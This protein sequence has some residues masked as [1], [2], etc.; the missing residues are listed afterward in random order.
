MPAGPGWRGRLSCQTFLT[1]SGD[2]REASLALSP[3][4]VERSRGLAQM[5][6]PFSTTAAKQYA[7]AVGIA[8]LSLGL[9]WAVI[10]LV[11]LRIPYMFF[12]I[13]I[14]AA[15]FYCGLGPALLVLLIGAI[16]ASGLFGRWGGLTIDN[17]ADLVALG[18]Y[19]LA[20]LAAIAIGAGT[21]SAHL[22][23]QRNLYDV[24]QLHGLG[25]QLAATPGLPEQLHLILTRLAGLIGADKGLLSFYDRAENRLKIATSFGFSPEGLAQLEGVRGGDGACG[26]ACLEGRRVVVRDTE[27]D[28][29]FRNF[30]NL[31]RQEGFRAVHSTPIFGADEQVLGAVTYH[32]AQIHAPDT[33]EKHLTEICARN[34]AVHVER[35]RSEEKL[36]EGELRLRRVVDASAVPFTIMQP[37]RDA[38]DSIVDF[39]WV[40]V[41]RSAA[42]IL[43]HE[44]SNLLGRKVS[45]VLPGTWDAPGLFDYYVAALLNNEV[46]EFEFHSVQNG[47]EGWFHVVAYELEGNLAIWFAD[48]TQRKSQEIELRTA[49]RRKDEFLATLAHELRNPLA[50]IRQAA[51]LLRKP[52]ASAAQK[53]WCN[54]VIERQVRQMSLLLDDLLDV[55]RITRGQLQLKKQPTRLRS[56]VDSAIETSRPLIDGKKHELVVTVDQGDCEIDVDPMR[57]EQVIANLLNNAAKYTPNRGHIR[58][59]ASVHEDRLLLSVSDTG[60]GMRAADLQSIFEMFSQV[61]SA[62]EFSEGGLGIGLAL[63]RGLVELHDGQIRAETAGPGKGSTFR[64]EI[65]RVI[66]AA[67]TDS[68]APL[69]VAQLSVSRRILVADDNR[70]AA[71]SLAM[72]LRSD[73]HQVLIAHDGESAVA[74]FLAHAPEIA[75][76]D[77]GMPRLSGYEVAR[78]I[79]AAPH[80]GAATLIAITGWGQGSDRAKSADAG[81]DHHVT[82]PVDYEALRQLL[83]SRR[84]PQR[85]DSRLSAER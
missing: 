40:Y 65:P 30:R 60:I 27:T 57:M 29:C 15:A 34:I 42:R 7:I 28:A 11:G 46:R 18:I 23:S 51:L 14:G 17:P 54:E 70:D 83:G 63:T 2:C 22:R 77:I 69:P 66:R 39:M 25:L 48:I 33:R 37:V 49:D 61:R 45:A 24:E 59:S 73:G 43:R 80:G 75:L 13:A 26:T 81:F 19:L 9:Q 50:P 36:R 72:L 4:R 10:P 20:G 44:A 6:T 31:A 21:R 67:A 12:L 82:K 64:V 53:E 58:L 84:V 16:N 1:A 78:R 32:F 35:S 38:A 52:N 3:G 68:V 71:D 56:L 41:N 85:T 5:T 8:L 74:Q 76:L 55:S 47:I 62:E 79:R